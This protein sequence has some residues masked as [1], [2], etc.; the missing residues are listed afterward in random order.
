MFGALSPAVIVSADVISENNAVAD[1]HTMN[2]DNIVYT[3]SENSYIKE[4]SNNNGIV[5]YL[6][7]EENGENN[8][9]EINRN[10]NEIS[11]NGQLIM[12]E[13]STSDD[14]ISS[15]AFQDAEPFSMIIPYSTAPTINY[16]TA[17]NAN[18]RIP[19]RGIAL[20]T[21]TLIGA[22]PG[23]G[24][25]IASAIA[26]SVAGYT[27]EWVHVTYTQ[28]RSNQTYTS[29][30]DGTRYNKVINRNVRV[31]KNSVSSGNLVYGPVHGSWFDPVRP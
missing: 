14:D 26:T 19:F 4:L 12:V 2:D 29:S 5:S 17:L 21:T 20:F 24:W 25:S 16:S 6:A 18:S 11:I 9:V 8:I 22:I 23:L 10:T 13:E 30:Y 1:L 7:V 3:F 27:P 15:L 31:Y 28:Y